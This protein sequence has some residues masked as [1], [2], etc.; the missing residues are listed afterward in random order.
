[1][2]YI[3]IQ[4]TTSII[5]VSLITFFLGY[6]T[7]ARVDDSNMHFWIAN[8]LVHPEHRSRGV[9]C[10]LWK[11]LYDH[12]I[13]EASDSMTSQADGNEV[14]VI[15]A[16]LQMGLGALMEEPICRFY[17]RCGFKRVAPSKEAAKEMESQ[18]D[19]TKWLGIL[20]HSYKN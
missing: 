17:E 2:G 7:A 12:I 14:K 1:M 16:P 20:N 11:Y 13:T 9:G 4:S 6:I 3:R 18:W 15:C 8:F 5:K 19:G 10:T